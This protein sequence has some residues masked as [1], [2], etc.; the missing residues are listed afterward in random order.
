M[1]D[2]VASS[3][4]ES[5]PFRIYVCGSFRDVQGSGREARAILERTE[6]GLQGIGFDA[7]T[8]RHPRAKE[9]AP[10]LDPA[11]MTRRLEEVSDFT[12]YIGIAIGRGEGWSSEFS[13]IQARYPEGARKR[14][15]LLH[16][17]YPLS[18]IVSNEYGGHASEPFVTII[19]WETEEQLLNI[20]TRLAVHLHERGD[21]PAVTKRPGR[22]KI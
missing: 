13:D 6:K 2:S 8:Q 5:R 11:P 14:A 1:T 3:T 18:Q 19:E 15:I 21:L 22:L 7:F 9:L 20:I 4:E 17:D 16:A 12:V 10:G